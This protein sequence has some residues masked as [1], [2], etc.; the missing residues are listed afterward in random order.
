MMKNIF[1]LLT[2]ILILGSVT[3][4][5]QYNIIPQPVSLIKKEGVFKTTFRSIIEKETTNN[6][7]FILENDL[8]IGKE[9]YVINIDNNR[10][11][12]KAS[13]EIG[14][15]Y[16]IQTLMQLMPPEVYKKDFNDNTVVELP[17]CEIKDFPRFPYRG[18][19][20][21]VSR[22]FFP[23]SFIK[24]YIDLMAMHKMNFFHWHLTDDQGWRIE[25]K[26]YPKLQEIAS[27]RDETWIG[28]I[29]PD[30]VMMENL[31]LVTILRRKSKKLLSMLNRNISPSFRK[32]R[33]LGMH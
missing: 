14:F 6:Q 12:V 10:L 15:F 33:C 8:E 4:Q 26:K 9:G 21:D 31:M 3:A 23:V 7:S 13:T 29:I 17:C 25:I 22:H 32:L 1:S 19:H 24:K 27:Q 28:I 18:L 2:F 30:W 5:N 16:A 20:L 11:E